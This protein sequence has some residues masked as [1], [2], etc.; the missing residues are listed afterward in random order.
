[1]TALSELES[2]AS[3]GL[4]TNDKLLASRFQYFIMYLEII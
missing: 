2:I 4:I 1:M 3:I